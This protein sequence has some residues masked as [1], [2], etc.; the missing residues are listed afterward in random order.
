MAER[1]IPANFR[2]ARRGNGQ[3]SIRWERMQKDSDQWKAFTV[4]M[5]EYQWINK[6]VA[7][8]KDMADALYDSC[9]GIA[10][11]AAALFE[12]VQLEAIRAEKETFDKNDF[13]KVLSKKFF[14]MERMIRAL[15]DNDKKAIARYEDISF[16]M[17]MNS[18]E[19]KEQ[20]A[21]E[22][23]PPKKNDIKYL[24]I[25]QLQE[26]GVLP[27]KARE[28]VEQAA[29][30]T[31][32]E[33]SQGK[34]LMAAFKLHMANEDQKEQDKDKNEEVEGDLRKIENYEEMKEHILE[35]VW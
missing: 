9:Q 33:V 7:W 18:A 1:L 22:P 21:G 15:R 14:F 4:S 24:T 10:V 23:R 6:T 2:Q 25:C 3:G 20:E 29:S 34:L 12:Q 11:L 17:L 28:Y 16:R 31:N 32:G 13:G 19:T 26:M 35:E 8:D 30:A 5:W 27:E